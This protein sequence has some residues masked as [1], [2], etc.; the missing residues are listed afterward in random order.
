M[1]VQ[2]LNSEIADHLS[3]AVR[4]LDEAYDLAKE[5]WGENDERTQ[6]INGAWSEVETAFR[7]F[8]KEPN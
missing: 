5:S 3:D 1:E 2:K 4:A 6:V 7:Q 8:H